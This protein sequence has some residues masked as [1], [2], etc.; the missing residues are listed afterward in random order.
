MSST[1]SR[2]NNLVAD[3]S[4]PVFLTQHD[5]HTQAAP[6]T[7]AYPRP[8]GIRGPEEKNLASY[9]QAVADLAI[10]RAADP[11]ASQ[12][13]H[14]VDICTRLVIFRQQPNTGGLVV[15]WYNQTDLR[16]LAIECA[17]LESLVKKTFEWHE[18][19]RFWIS[20]TRFPTVKKSLLL[21]TD[22]IWVSATEQFYQQFIEDV[23]KR[24]ARGDGVPIIIGV[25]ITTAFGP[26]APASRQQAQ[27]TSGHVM[28]VE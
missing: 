6:R 17:S 7:Q 15:E 20:T 26:P 4:A 24:A 1:S 18:C 21:K 23:V 2:S 9:E 10:Q 5:S 3:I 11:I 8:R 25:N 27:L 19:L 16:L 14:G 22:D 28:E 12:S 13:L